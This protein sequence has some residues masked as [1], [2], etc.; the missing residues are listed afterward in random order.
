[1]KLADLFEG[2]ELA[3]RQAQY[4]ANAKAKR[5]ALQKAKSDERL[6]HG[7]VM[8]E[9]AKKLP[10]YKALAAIA[11]DMTSEADHKRKIFYF[12]GSAA[13]GLKHRS[14]IDSYEFEVSE[15][16]AKYKRVG[17]QVWTPIKEG[18]L[19]NV[20]LSVPEDDNLAS[21]DRSLQLAYEKFKSEIELVKH[22][23]GD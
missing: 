4:A 11:D 12:A 15:R 13:Q 18:G 7:S 17:S 8:I 2:D 9:A 5:N 16:S 19:Y 10:S 23:L 21:F 20:K 14:P 6:K 1:M 22:H 3:N